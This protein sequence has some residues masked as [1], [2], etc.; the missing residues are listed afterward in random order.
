[1]TLMLERFPACL[2]ILALSA[3]DL[4]PPATPP[5]GRPMPTLQA[6]TPRPAARTA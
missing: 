1:M 6:P 4:M 5:A 3:C 2:A